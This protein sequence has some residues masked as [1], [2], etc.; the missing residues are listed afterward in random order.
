M[1]AVRLPDCCVPDLGSFHHNEV[2]GDK[3][4]R[5][6]GPS[7]CKDCLSRPYLSH[8]KHV[9]PDHLQARVLR[10]L[11]SSLHLETNRHL[12]LRRLFLLADSVRSE[13]LSGKLQSS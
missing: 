3:K 7:E 1:L 10:I 6:D 9:R 2:F 5:K 12:D 11:E 13:S 4:N 8:Y